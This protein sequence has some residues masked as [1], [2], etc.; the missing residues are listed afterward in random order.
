MKFAEM[1][2]RKSPGPR[3]RVGATQQEAAALAE[4]RE[5]F[6]PVA[7]KAKQYFEHPIINGKCR[8]WLLNTEDYDD[9]PHDKIVYVLKYK[10][11]FLSEIK[12]R[13]SVV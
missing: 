9:L 10:Q 7:A 4:F 1:F 2:P 8:F 11:W 5:T 3:K 13:K 6:G 12:D